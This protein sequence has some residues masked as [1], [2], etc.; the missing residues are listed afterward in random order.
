MYYLSIDEV[1]SR[2][3]IAVLDERERSHGV[4][5][6]PIALDIGHLIDIILY[7]YFALITM[8]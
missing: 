7:N 6:H 2:E 1:A 4:I 5:D 8:E 3:L